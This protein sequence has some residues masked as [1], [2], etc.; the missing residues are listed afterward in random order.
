MS[1]TI[2]SQAQF[3]FDHTKQINSAIETKNEAFRYVDRQISLAGQALGYKFEEYAKYVKYLFLDESD[4]VYYTFITEDLFEGLGKIE[5]IIELWKAKGITS[6]DELDEKLKDNESFKHLQH[7]LS[8]GKDYLHYLSKS[9]FLTKS[10][11]KDLKTFI[12]NTLQSDFEV[13]M[14]DIHKILKTI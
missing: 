11:I 1:D 13:I 14:K 8:G 12:I 2:N 7:R 3:Y 9:Y 4:L 6:A 10:D 5:I